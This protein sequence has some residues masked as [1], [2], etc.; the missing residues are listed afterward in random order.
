[1]EGFRGALPFLRRLQKK[2]YRAG[3]RFLVKRYQR[4]VRCPSCAGARLRSE[5]RWVHVL[6]DNIVDV[7][8]R[9][10]SEARVWVER[11]AASLAGEK[12]ALAA[13]ILKEL[14]SRLLYLERVDLGYLTLDRLAR[15]LSGGEAQRI[16]LSNALG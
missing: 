14:L 8:R 1:S 12:R 3:N 4:P 6:G 11:A 9:T 5:A 2:S 15:T 16:E 10:V 7:A 13:P